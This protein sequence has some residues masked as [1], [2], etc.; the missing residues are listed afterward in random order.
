MKKFILVVLVCILSVSLYSQERINEDLGIITEMSKRIDVHFKWSYRDGFWKGISY[1]NVGYKVQMIKVRYKDNNYIYLAILNKWVRRNWVT[2]QIT[3]SKRLV[4]Y[5]IK[6]SD[7]KSI[8]ASGINKKNKVTLKPP[9]VMR[10]F[11]D[12]PQLMYKINDDNSEYVN[13]KES[14]GEYSVVFQNYTNKD[15]VT[16]GRFS[17]DII[18]MRPPLIS[19]DYET[20]YTEFVG[21]LQDFKLIK[22]NNN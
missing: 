3:S 13:P 9:I 14:D 6:E 17:A 18:E 7:Y 22:L 5:E 8:V 12:I 2:E 19:Y 20:D 10:E 1:P 21:S 11:K 16:V 15:G 4:L